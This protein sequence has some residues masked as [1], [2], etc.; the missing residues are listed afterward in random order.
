MLTPLQIIATYP[1]HFTSEFCKELPDNLHVY[2][3]IERIALT[4]AAKRN[5]YAIDNIVASLRFD[6]AMAEAGS[7]GFKMQNNFR[8]YYAR[9]FHFQHPNHRIFRMKRT[10]VERF[11][12]VYPPL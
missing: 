4:I 9:V 3:A 6:T 11:N 8:A 10:A 12:D 5:K 7:S 2:A 1:Q